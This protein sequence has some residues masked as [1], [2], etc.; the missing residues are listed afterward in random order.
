MTTVIPL[1]VFTCELQGTRLIEASAGTGKTWNICG[2]YL[3]LVLEKNLEVQQ[4]LVVTFTNA[5]TAELRERIRERI[6]QVL[7]RLQ[8]RG[9]V[10]ADPFV[11][12]FLA[13]VRAQG[14]LT[15]KEMTA[16]VTRA[17]RN[18]DEA[19]IFTIH[20]FCKRALDD[21]PFA[22][23]LPL[24]QELITD[25]AELRHEV[26]TDFWRRNV[27]GGAIQPELAAFLL[28]CKE[29]PDLLGRLIQR[30][31]AKPMSRTLW[32]EGTAGDGP[33][34]D[35]SAL[36]AAHARA[37]ALWQ[38]QRQTILD[39][40]NTARESLD[41]RFYKPAAVEAC[42]E[43]WDALL[44]S[45]DALACLGA[46]NKL[47]LFTPLRL[48]P[49][50]GHTACEAHPFF[51]AAGQL[52]DA[53]NALAP[54]LVS[55]RLQ[56]LRRAAEAGPDQLRALKRERRLV[57]FDDMLFNLHERLEEPTNPWLAQS[58]RRR[59]PAALIDE[60]QDTDPLQFSIFQ[61]V[62]GGAGDAALLFLVGDP[63]QAIYSFRNADLHTYLQ[64]R[65]LAQAEYTLVENQRST[66][67]LLNG[68]NALFGA[69]PQAFML[70]GLE[71][72]EVKAGAK[73]R[74]ALVD[75]SGPAVPL[76]LWNLAP[77][78][79]GNPSNKRAATRAA[80]RACAAEIARLLAAGQRDEITLDNRPLRAGDIAVLVR[81]HSQGN[82]MRQALGALGVGS[83]EL[84]QTSV[85]EAPE[86][87]DLERVLTAILE[88]ARETLLRA[89]LATE[90]LG[91]NAL[92]IDA[93]AADERAMM[94]W[95]VRFSSYRTS[96]VQRGIGLMLREFIAAEGVNE[97]MLAR[98]D[99]E[100]RLTNLRH[101]SECL[102]EAAQQHTSPEALLRWLKRQ[103]SEPEKQ[104]ATQLRLESDRNLVQIITIHKAKGLEYPIVFCPFLWN[105]HP[106]G[107]PGEL[108][109]R[110][111]HDEDG[112]PVI[113]YREPEAKDAISKAICL[114]RDAERL[115]LIYV[116]LTRAVHRLYLVVGTYTNK[117]GRNVLT[118]ECSR[119]PLNWLV[120]GAGQ[121]PEQWLE[122]KEPAATITAAWATLAKANTPHIGITEV[123]GQAGTPVD[124]PRPAPDT[125]VAREAPRQIPQGWRMASY[126]SLTHGARNEAG[127]ADHDLR[128]AQAVLPSPAVQLAT[129]EGDDILRFPRGARAGECLHTVFERV[130]FT[131]SSGWP[132]SAAAALRAKPPE[133]GRASPAQLEPMVQRMLGDVLQTQ[134]LPGLSLSMIPRARRLVEMEFNLY[135]PALDPLVLRAALERQG[136]PVP[137]L[138]AQ[139]LEGY[140]RGFIDLVFEH[141]GRFHILDWKSNHLGYGADD[142]GPAQLRRAM[143][144]HGYHLQ[145]LLYTVAL[146]RWLQRRRPGYNY[147]QHFG[148]VL[149]LFVRGV[150]P[151]WTLADGSQAGVFFE[152]PKLELVE[153]L[154]DVLGQAQRRAA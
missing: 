86:A 38:G 108:M 61:K 105:G 120:A 25:D 35:A 92:A 150:R 1:N 128:V 74:K 34:V 80:V 77:D 75:K 132:A 151:A 102:H 87:E 17:L 24:M 135:A 83:V 104:E 79:L 41:G 16:R 12:T 66:E 126:S 98:P 49:K 144:E 134:L 62:Y 69:N 106:G 33:I 10:S 13:T 101:L 20:G 42:I 107:R 39:C 58:L 28:E 8:Q 71:Y 22:A 29:S 131:D 149:Y 44:A 84:S 90:L 31:V 27:A 88:P 78:E 2:L 122:N 140:L 3:R 110:L 95:L 60:F 9:A 154:S 18:F 125:L 81:T 67:E 145:Y 47:D 119:N 112:K 48:K 141:Q 136:Y 70:P 129:V 76:Q 4:I 53:W 56:L 21:A 65:P 97:R 64:A 30:H 91:L 153:H 40:I 57:A 26:A 99:G 36:R 85:F 43:Q 94:A 109:G 118:T 82:A 113:D 19:A 103:R 147:D 114:E 89:A 68:L 23:G 127:A 116:A 45:D 46:G 142:Y 14:T 146:H 121:S 63:K 111:Y 59:F 37:R 15:A 124:L 7:T 32:P 6:A 148:G 93:L 11:D 115:R 5:A 54:Q 96:W 123:P 133:A 72:R 138:G 55:A 139:R 100:R 52:L 152:R 73:P 137:P 143:E 117:V 51:E 50:K 130:D